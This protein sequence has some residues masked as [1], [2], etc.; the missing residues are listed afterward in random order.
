MYPK[1]LSMQ[2][3][4]DV[5]VCVYICFIYDMIMYHQCLA[6][7][8]TY[9]HQGIFS[10]AWFFRSSN[11]APWWSFSFYLFFLSSII[12]SSRELALCMMCPKYDILSLVICTEVRS[13]SNLIKILY[14]LLFLMLQEIY[15]N[16]KSTFLFCIHVL[17]PYS[18]TWIT[19]IACT[20]LIFVAT[21]HH[22]LWTSFPR[23][24]LQHILTTGFYCW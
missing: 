7:T 23:A 24:N 9:F 8:L 20:I 6:T 10:R 15:T 19:Y 4:W 14:F 2:T 1:E 21:T 12:G 13:L 22:I 5:C 17:F 18:T 11:C 16:F 3:S